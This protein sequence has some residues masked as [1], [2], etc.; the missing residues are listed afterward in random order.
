MGKLGILC[1]M[2]ALGVA[3]CHPAEVPPVPPPK[4]TDPAIA[5]RSPAGQV[6]DA[7]IFSEGGGDRDSGFQLDTGATERTACAGAGGK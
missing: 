6:I 5:E 4:P 7:S 1:A 3:S 2:T